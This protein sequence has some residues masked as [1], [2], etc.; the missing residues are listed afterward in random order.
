MKLYVRAVP[1]GYRRKPRYEIR[2]ETA[3]IGFLIGV[4]NCGDGD[5]DAKHARLFAAA[6]DLLEAAQAADCACS[7]RERDSGHR[8]GCWM[9]ALQA[10]IAKAT[11]PTERSAS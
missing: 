4:C 11:T 2:T 6:P 3:G 9:P 10:A 7:V 1:A 5:E 8:T